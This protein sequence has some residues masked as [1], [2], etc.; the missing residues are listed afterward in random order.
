MTR[1]VIMYTKSVCPNCDQAKTMLKHVPVEID[2]EVRNIE[3]D[4]SYMYA[5]TII[6]ESMT[7]P[8]FHFPDT[9]RVIRGWIDGEIREELGL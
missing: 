2:L 3:E 8:T 7:T 4:E 1:K 9:N 6:H 5:M